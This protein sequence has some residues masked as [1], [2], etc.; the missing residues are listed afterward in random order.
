MANPHH[1]SL[2]HSLCVLS[3]LTSEKAVQEKISRA[4]GL[5]FGREFKRDLPQ[6]V[7]EAHEIG[8]STVGPCYTT[9]TDYHGSDRVPL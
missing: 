8:N 4:D 3:E 5:F 7:T 9:Y 2:Y 6:F 1:T